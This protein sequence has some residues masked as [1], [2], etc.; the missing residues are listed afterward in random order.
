MNL[1][2]KR[3]RGAG[4]SRYFVVMRDLSELMARYRIELIAPDGSIHRRDAM[5]CAHDDDAIDRVG[6][7]DYP[8]EIDV[9]EGERLVARFPP[10][11]GPRFGPGLS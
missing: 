7:L 8:H 9:W 5:D 3:Q 1:F 6:K 11:R 2:D 10:W 4:S